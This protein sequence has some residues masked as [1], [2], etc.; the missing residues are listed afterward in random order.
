MKMH[1]LH[2]C[3][4][5]IKHSAAK[6]SD[7]RFHLSGLTVTFFRAAVNQASPHL[8]LRATYWKRIGMKYQCLPPPRMEK[9][10]VSARLCASAFLP[11]SQLIGT[12]I[13]QA[14]SGNRSPEGHP[15]ARGLHSH[16]APTPIHNLFTSHNPFNLFHIRRATSGCV[17]CDRLAAI[18]LSHTS[19]QSAASVY[20]Q[21]YYTFSFN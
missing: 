10:L 7:K 19:S 21:Y 3:S 13:N 5:A 16:P 11:R 6:R 9:L 8:R 18:H 1:F 17:R 15:P 20:N 2:E 14:C 4:A 12:L